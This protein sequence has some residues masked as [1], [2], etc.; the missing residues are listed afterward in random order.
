MSASAPIIRGADDVD[1]HHR[2]SAVEAVRPRSGGEGEQQPWQPADQRD[3]G[4]RSGV[5]GDPEG[6]QR[7]RDLEGSVGEVRQ[8]GRAHQPREVATESH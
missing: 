8:T 3:R 2:A 1:E 5:A 6:D 7:Q 4:E